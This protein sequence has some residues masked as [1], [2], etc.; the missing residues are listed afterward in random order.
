MLKKE[1]LETARLAQERIYPSN[2]DYT[3]HVDQYRSFFD[4]VRHIMEECSRLL[5]TL[6]CVA[7]LRSIEGISAVDDLTTLLKNSC[8]VAY[9]PSLRPIQGRCPVPYCATELHR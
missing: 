9:Q 6:F 3:F 7:L 2:R 4:R 8:R 1:E 5:S